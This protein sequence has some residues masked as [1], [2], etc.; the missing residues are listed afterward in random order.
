VL[1]EP[2]PRQENTA[3][4]TDAEAVVGVRKDEPNN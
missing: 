2:G 4:A 3:S 1:G